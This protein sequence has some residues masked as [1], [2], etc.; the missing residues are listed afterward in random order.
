MLGM[1]LLA[2]A[3]AMT[4]ADPAGSPSDPDT[5]AEEPITPVPHPIGQDAARVALGAGLFADTRLSGDGRRSCASCHDLN[6][7]GA[8]TNRF[9]DQADGSPLPVNTPTVFKASLNFRQTWSGRIRTLEQQAEASIK[10]PGFMNTTLPTVVAR[11]SA[12]PGL[13]VAFRAAYGHGPDGPSV[14]DAL[15]SFERTLLTPDSPF[16]RWSQGDASALSPDA[17]SGYRLFR[18]VGCVSCHQGQNVGGNPFE[19]AGIF[20]NVDD[21]RWPL[22]RVPSLRNV[23]VTPP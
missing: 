5:R 20:R 22:L 10:N 3:P 14:L 2:S 12:D 18:S 1:F 19:R 6:T 13:V 23:A 17:V 15:A 4:T 8:T 9:D 16:D 7:N 11:L 21:P